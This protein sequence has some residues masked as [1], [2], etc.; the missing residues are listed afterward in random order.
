MT[1]FELTCSD[2]FAAIPWPQMLFAL[3]VGFVVG[4]LLGFLYGR[5]HPRPP[6]REQE[7]NDDA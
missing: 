4:G 5:T 6:S 2:Y 1:P 3:V 7:G